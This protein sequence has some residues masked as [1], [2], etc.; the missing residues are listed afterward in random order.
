METKTPVKN[1]DNYKSDITAVGISIDDQ[2]NAFG[3]ELMKQNIRAENYDSDYEES[4][5][6][7][8]AR[9]SNNQNLREV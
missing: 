7:F 3:Q 5:N 6:N 8:V 9:I 2:V 4:E 1:E